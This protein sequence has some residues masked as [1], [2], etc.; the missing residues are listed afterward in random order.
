M[1]ST[2]VHAY[3]PLGRATRM[4]ARAFINFLLDE[5]GESADVSRAG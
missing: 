1:V 4:A 2:D 5:F 3:F